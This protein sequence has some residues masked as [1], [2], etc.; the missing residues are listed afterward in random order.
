MTPN[1]F[2]VLHIYRRYSALVLL[3]FV[4]FVLINMGNLISFAFFLIQ[5]FKFS[6]EIS[7]VLSFLPLIVPP[8]N[9]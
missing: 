4:H 6:F 1:I 5:L 7:F 9:R 3:L 2:L 8:R